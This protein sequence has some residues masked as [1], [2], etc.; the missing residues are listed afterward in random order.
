[1]GE[2]GTPIVL[3]WP[4]Q[5]VSVELVARAVEKVVT[6]IATNIV[7]QRCH[8]AAI[9]MD[10]LTRATCIQNGISDHECYPG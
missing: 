1:M 9:G 2:G 10:I 6:V 3:Q 8:C 5:G 7:T 4:Q